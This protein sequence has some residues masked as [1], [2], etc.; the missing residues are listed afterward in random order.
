[1]SDDKDVKGLTAKVKEFSAKLQELTAKYGDDEDKRHYIVMRRSVLAKMREETFKVLAKLVNRDLDYIADTFVGAWPDN[2]EYVQ[3]VLELC[4]Q[5]KEGKWGY[6]ELMRRLAREF[7]KE[8]KADEKGET[9]YERDQIEKNLKRVEKG[10]VLEYRGWAEMPRD[11]IN[12]D[13]IDRNLEGTWPTNPK[14]RKKVLTAFR[15]YKNG[16]ISLAT[17]RTRLEKA[18]TDEYLREVDVLVQK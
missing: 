9:Y 13:D 4:R 6:V 17:L 16:K 15:Q 7:E 10:V 12:L 5:F 14:H 8:M 1:M 11:I 18:V 2:P 3:R